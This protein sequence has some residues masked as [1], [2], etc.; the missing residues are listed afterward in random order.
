VLVT[1]AT[2]GLGKA[3]AAELAGAG[4]TVLLHGRDHERGE[5][6]LAELRAQTGSE[7]LRWYRADLSSLAEVHSLAAQVAAEHER[8][9][10]L[11]NNAG[12]GTNLPGDGHRMQSADGHELRFAVNYLAPFLLTRL[13]QPLLVG[14]APARIVN[15][16]SA[17]QAPIDFDDVM[18]ERGYNGVQAY[19]QSKLALVML[20]FDLAEKL[21]EYGVTA[22][23]LHPG[24]YMP[25]K[26]VFAA[27]VTPHDS[28]ETGVRA[29]AR[30]VTAPELADVSGRY[31]DRL[32]EARGHR[33]AYDAEARRRL[34]ELSEHLTGLA[35][36][37]SRRLPVEGTAN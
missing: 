2:D 16:S 6:T 9:D 22:N 7:T 17:G 1:G 23:C 32:A 19:C 18:L 4:A 25:T 11:V 5:R 27:G 30:L 15:I 24:T 21:G 12:I 26:M 29:T 14:S 3:L 33:Q 34:R 37:L 8:L 35:A 31:F 20:T 10:V 28:L 36:P 13:L